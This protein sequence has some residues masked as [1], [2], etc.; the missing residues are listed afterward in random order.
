MFF[1]WLAESAI[2]AGQKWMASGPIAAVLTRAFPVVSLLAPSSA[3]SDSYIGARD[4]LV[5][6]YKSDSSAESKD[7]KKSS[8]LKCFP[9]GF[10]GLSF[11]NVSSIIRTLVKTDQSSECF[12]FPTV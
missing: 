4:C 12:F 2:L 9:V 1:V 5:I 8:Y 10:S 11:S 3:A 6:G 7:G